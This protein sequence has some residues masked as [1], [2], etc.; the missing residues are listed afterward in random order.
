MHAL[1]RALGRVASLYSPTGDGA[2]LHEYMAN[3]V[4]DVARDFLDPDD[5][6][7]LNRPTKLTDAQ[8]RQVYRPQLDALLTALTEAEA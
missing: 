2:E 4:S 3:L 5:A 1:V 8:R 6:Q 7:D